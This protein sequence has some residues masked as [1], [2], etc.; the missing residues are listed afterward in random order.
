MDQERFGLLSDKY[1]RAT[2]T[3]ILSS[4]QHEQSQVQ[5]QR[6]PRGKG[7][8]SLAALENPDVR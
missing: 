6:L 7:H 1:R 5:L 4:A 3:S 2:G 8:T